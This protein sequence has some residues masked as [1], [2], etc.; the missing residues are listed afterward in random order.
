MQPMQVA[1]FSF[2]S[3]LIVLVLL[4]C[5]CAYI[6]PH[7]G[8]INNNPRG[9][10]GTPF[11]LARLGERLSPAVAIACMILAAYVLFIQ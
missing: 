5:T 3:M 10:V 1:I 11:K 8:W 4:I 9:F 7:V 2:T 6:R